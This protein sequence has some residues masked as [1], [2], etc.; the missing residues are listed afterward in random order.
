MRCSV[1]LVLCLSSVSLGQEVPDRTAK[2]TLKT[3]GLFHAAAKGSGDVLQAAATEIGGDSAALAAKISAS[4]VATA[5]S[6]TVKTPAGT[7]AKRPGVARN[8]LDPDTTVKLLTEVFSEFAR[9]AYTEHHANTSD[10]AKLEADLHA[11]IQTRV[12]KS[13]PFV[14]QE[15]KPYLDAVEQ[16]VRTLSSSLDLKVGLHA[17]LVLAGMADGF[18]KLSL[19]HGEFESFFAA[20]PVG[21][22]GASGAA[23]TDSRI[24]GGTS[25]RSGAEGDDCRPKRRRATCLRLLLLGL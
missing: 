24:N 9:R 11:A 3:G 14:E 7:V 12:W 8:D 6:W 5:K 21:T 20:Q 10:V 18:V 1:L 17:A 23:Y 15:W 2:P 25:L 13:G 4:V 16:S 19:F 22:G